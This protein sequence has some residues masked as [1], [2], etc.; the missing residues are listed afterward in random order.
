MNDGQFESYLSRVLEN[1]LSAEEF[2]EFERH[3][4]SSPE[5]R[6]QYLDAVD[7]HNLLDLSLQAKIP[8]QRG[9]SNVVDVQRIIGKQRRKSM[10]IAAMS[11]AAIFVI[12][13]ACLGFFM[14]KERPPALAFNTSPGTDFTLTHSKDASE[15]EGR[16]MEAGS[17]LHLT[18]GTVELSFASGVRSIVKAPAD[19]TLH[20]DDTLFVNQGTAWF[21]VPENAIGFT[22]KSKELTAVDLG[23]E[24]GVIVK[25]NDY[26]EVHVFKGKVRV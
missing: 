12:G 3:L 26:D 10:R 9:I 5:A 21:E 20:Q 7:V 17:R 16:I 19:I 14:V 25:P 22:V 6:A 4:A 13:L 24:F 11:A 15:A 18:T 1:D 2:A 8:T 23:T